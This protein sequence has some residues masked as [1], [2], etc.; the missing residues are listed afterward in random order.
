[1]K[2]FFEELKKRRVYRVA[3][4]YLIIGS[5]VVQLAGMLALAYGRIDDAVAEG[6]RT[7]LLDPNYIYQGSVLAAAYR[8]KGMFAEA[9]ELYKKATEVTGVP[10]AGLAIT[11]IKMGRS[12]EALRLL[13]DLKNFSATHYYSGEEIA[14]IYAAL[15]DDDAAFEWLERAYREH[16]GSLHGIVTLRVFR[17]LY[18]DPRFADLLK[19]IGLDPAKVFAAS[20]RF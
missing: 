2:T 20:K 15:D 18:S 12:D 11:Y 14:S 5:A 1:M 4:V 8:E 6:R 19:R 9:V 13:N 3:F 17:P 16:S 7:Q 10:Q